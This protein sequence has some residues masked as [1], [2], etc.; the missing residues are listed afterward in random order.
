MTEAEWVQARNPTSMVAWLLEQEPRDSTRLDRFAAAY[1]D[2]DYSATAP[3]LRAVVYSSGRP[4]LYLA[5]SDN[6]DQWS[7]LFDPAT[8]LPLLRC[9]FG[10]PFRPVA[11]DPA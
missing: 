5:A 4:L 10:N 11:V 6:S 3:H 7:H 1:Y 8:A 9:F 2:W